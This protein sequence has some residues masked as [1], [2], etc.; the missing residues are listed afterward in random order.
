[1]CAFLYYAVSS[2]MQYVK[3]SVFVLIQF[4]INLI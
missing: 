3:V 1:M 4:V 2:R